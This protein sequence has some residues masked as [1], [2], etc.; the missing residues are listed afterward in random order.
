M[1]RLDQQPVFGPRGAKRELN[2]I[3]RLNFPV[4]HS[5][6]RQPAVDPDSCLPSR[7]E[8]QGRGAV[9]PGIDVRQIVKGSIP[10][11]AP[12]DRIGVD[13]AVLRK[14]RQRLPF[15][16]P[17]AAQ[18]RCRV[19]RIGIRFRRTRQSN[20][21][22]IRAHDPPARLQEAVQL[23]LAQSSPTRRRRRRACAGPVRR[24]SCPFAIQV[25]GLS[26]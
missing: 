10:L 1:P 20:L 23:S 12:G 22:R 8:V 21:F 25:I 6:E 9:A 16:L 11:F 26:P 5:V 19:G 18:C 15:Q 17:L 7:P 14:R 4:H 3:A 2:V 13:A 24:A